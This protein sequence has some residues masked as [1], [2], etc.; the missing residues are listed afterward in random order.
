MP[1]GGPGRRCAGTSEFWAGVCGS[2]V[3]P[4]YRSLVTVHAAPVIGRPVRA[5]AWFEANLPWPQVP[6]GLCQ[7]MFPFHTEMATGTCCRLET[8]VRPSPICGEVLL[9]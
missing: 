2:V 3:A 1:G 7:A 5:R 6:S 8:T 9:S 4:I